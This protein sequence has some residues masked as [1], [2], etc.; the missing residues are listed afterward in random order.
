MPRGVYQRKP[1]ANTKAVRIKDNLAVAKHIEAITKQPR[2]GQPIPTERYL[3]LAC[4]KM[5]LEM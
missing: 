3:A 1:K 5:I 2:Q 4:L